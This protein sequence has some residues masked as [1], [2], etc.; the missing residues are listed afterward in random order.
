[1]KRCLISREELAVHE[2][3]HLIAIA[4]TPD[5][6]PGEFIWHRL[7]NYEIAHVEPVRSAHFDW[8]TPDHRNALIVKHVVVALAGGAAE[9][10]WAAGEWQDH[11]SIEAIHERVGRI[12]FELAHEWLTLQRYDPD[13]GSLE[14]EIKRLFLEVYEVLGQPAQQTAILALRQRILDQLRATDRTG[15]NSLKLPASVLLDGIELDQGAHFAL[16]A[17]LFSERDT[18]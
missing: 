9:L 5:L 1:M 10:C 4:M 7:P 15:A 13:Q 17:T 18:H 16:K 14:L 3:G 8:E 2:A 12:D 11:L 6:E